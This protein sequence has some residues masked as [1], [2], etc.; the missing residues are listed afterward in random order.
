MKD[1]A[2]NDQH[3]HAMMLLSKEKARA[4]G[5]G[6]SIKVNKRSRLD[7]DS[8]DDL[9]ALNVE[10]VLLTSFNPDPCIDLWWGA[11][12]RRPQQRPRRK[13]RSRTLKEKSTTTSESETATSTTSFLSDSG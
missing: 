4:A 10:K 9:L 8:L 1:H 12:H 13:Y 7:N 3:T 5:Q 6:P 11:K 2:K